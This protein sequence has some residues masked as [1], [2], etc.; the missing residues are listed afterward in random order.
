MKFNPK[1]RI[2][3][4]AARDEGRYAMQHALFDG[5]R[6]VATD[7]RVLVIIPAEA[8]EGDTPGLVTPE[9]LALARKVAPKGGDAS[10]RC[11]GCLEAGGQKLD[12]PEGEFPRWQAVMPSPAL[13]TGER[14]VLNRAFLLRALEAMGDGTHLVI[15]L[16][17][18]QAS[19]APIYL[20]TLR[21]EEGASK[22]PV[23]GTGPRAVVM[24]VTL[25]FAGEPD[26]T[27][28]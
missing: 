22:L 4:A 12:R 8:E 25:E 5:E 19:K 26:A 27:D 28:A 11:N 7:G 21:V 3:K 23:L 10:V 24:P 1:T 16:A 9:A 2:E 15:Q 6:L 14:V 17:A 20:E 18:H 13:G